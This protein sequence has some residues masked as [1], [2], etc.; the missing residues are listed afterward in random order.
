MV[1]INLYASILRSGNAERASS[2]FDQQDLQETAML[3]G[4]FVDIVHLSSLI[5]QSVI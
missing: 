1:S 5:S 2:A 4:L 3:S